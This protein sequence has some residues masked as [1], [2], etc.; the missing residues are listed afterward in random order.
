M[1]LLHPRRQANGEKYITFTSPKVTDTAIQ[2]VHSKSSKVIIFSLS[3]NN[4]CCH[5]KPKL[6]KRD[7]HTHTCICIP[8]VLSWNYNLYIVK[9]TNH[10]STQVCSLITSQIQTFFE[11]S[12]TLPCALTQS[13]AISKGNHTLDHPYHRLV[14]PV[15]G[16][17]LNGMYS[18]E[19]SFFHT[20]L[21]W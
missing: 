12:P 1:I 15:P 9:C 11:Q 10:E 4:T 8:N 13:T 5:F 21:Y 3:L 14:L 6:Q 17:H 20:T 16:S 19:S 7:A 18:F 2:N